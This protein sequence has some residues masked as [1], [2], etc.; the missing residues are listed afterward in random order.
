MVPTSIGMTVPAAKFC[1][2]MKAL[3]NLKG[4]SVNSKYIGADQVK[5]GLNDQHAELA[6]AA[7]DLKAEPPG[8]RK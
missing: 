1:R 3:A 7:L 2:A 5:C 8:T 6:N 4:Y